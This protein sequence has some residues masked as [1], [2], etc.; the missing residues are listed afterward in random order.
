MKQQDLF[1][2]SAPKPSEPV[3]KADPVAPPSEPEWVRAGTTAAE[4]PVVVAA[5][6]LPR[7]AL[8][9][10]KSEP[11]VL[12]VGQLT[13]ALKETIEPVF[14]RVLVRG[15]VSGFRGPNVRGH[16]YFAL[17]DDVSS[18]DIKVWQTTAARM[19]FALRDGLSVIVEGS[20]DLYEPSGRYSLIVQ[21]ID[22]TGVGAQA[23]AYEQLKAKL[24]AEGLF[25]PNRKKPRRPL[26]TLPRRIGVVTS[27]SGAALRDF[28]KVLHRRHPRLAVLVADTRVQGEGAALEIARAIRR[29]GRQNVDVIVVTRGGGSAE[30]LWAFNEET[31]AR[32]IFECPLPVV[33]AVGHEVD[34]TL[35]DYVADLRAPTPSAA[36]EAIAPVLADLQ[37]HLATT[38]ARL[39]KAVER[40]ILEGHHRLGSLQATL[41]DPR[42]GLSQRRL[43]LS[44]LVEKMRAGLERTTRE[45]REVLRALNVKLHQL[46]PQAQLLATRK[47]LHQLAARLQSAASFTFRRERDGLALWRDRLHHVSPKPA[48][49]AARAALQTVK[50]RLPM[51]M[52]RTLVR[53]RV[54]LAALEGQLDA[55][56]PLKV[57]SRGYAIAFAS[58]DGRAVRSASDVKPGDGLR[59]RLQ[60]GEVDA[61]VTG[62]RQTSYTARRDDDQSG[63]D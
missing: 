53:E 57:L 3:G 44:E 2:G 46:R 23:L 45:R 22:P 62:S 37:L 30:D 56:S 15:E 21:R 50:G 40:R 19:K 58:A 6:Q 61:T 13:R 4:K 49:H 24:M 26:P 16:L 8:P 10:L 63:E 5:P 14:G 1:G 7:P 48:A 12:T 31:V 32:A 47:A 9:V 27:I 18:I 51:L 25:G 28:L 39:R 59:I 29:L 33:S 35:A 55:L 34:T 36:A 42:R 54:A 11:K 60:E 38:R 43:Q 52:G 17:K 20:I 41:K